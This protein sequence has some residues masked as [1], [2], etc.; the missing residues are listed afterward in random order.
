MWVSSSV[1]VAVAKATAATPIQPLT[2]N[3]NSIPGLEL[4]YATGAA[5]KKE[6]KKDLTML[7]YLSLSYF[8]T[9]L[10]NGIINF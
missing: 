6:K 9:F 7:K 1:A 10:T 2:W 4:P 8:L 5:V 3:F